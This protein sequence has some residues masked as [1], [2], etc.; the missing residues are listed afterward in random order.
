MKH[1]YSADDLAEIESMFGEGRGN[2]PAPIKVYS[3]D[4]L[5]EIAQQ[6]ERAETPLEMAVVADA[7][8]CLIG[9]INALMID[10]TELQ[11]ALKKAKE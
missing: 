7:V 3:A 5:A 2:G 11:V 4:D 6:Y 8:P 10:I 9:Q 1:G